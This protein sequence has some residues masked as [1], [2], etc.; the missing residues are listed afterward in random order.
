M[1]GH[2]AVSAQ[3]YEIVEAV[4]ALLAAPHLVVNLQ[5]FEGSAPLAPPAVP[6]E[7]LLHQSAIDLLPQLDPLHSLQHF[8][9]GSG[10]VASDLEARRA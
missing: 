5:V 3:G 6:L 2:M 10:S 8:L 7:N 4:V 1:L 9:T